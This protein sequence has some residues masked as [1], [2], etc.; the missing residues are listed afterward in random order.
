MRKEI[1]SRP[2]INLQPDMLPLTIEAYASK[3]SQSVRAVRGQVARGHL[4]VIRTDSCASVYI[5]QAQMIM[6]SLESAG[7]DVKVTSRA[8]S[9]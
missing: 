2:V 1:E 4:P 3:T 5:N 6:A 8:Y 9:L 7:W